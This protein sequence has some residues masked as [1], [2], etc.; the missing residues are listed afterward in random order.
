MYNLAAQKIMETKIKAIIF[1]M[2]GVLIDSEPLWREAM[3][4]GFNDLG[5]KFTEEDCK[6]TTGMRFKEV[7]EHWFVEFN[8]KEKTVAWFD[9]YVET[10][11]IELIQKGGR[12]IK[13]ITELLNFLKEK[14]YKIGLATSSNKKLMYAVLKH[15][16]LGH[17]FSATCSAQTLKYGKPHPK[18]FLNCASALNCLPQECLVIE[19]SVNGV[20]AAKAAFM[21]V[22][23]VPELSQL[24]NPKFA[25]ANYT[26]KNMKEVKSII[27]KF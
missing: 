22:I 15:L 11:L 6:K 10:L 26:C 3:I 23:A 4:K 16:K 25:I 9:K 18:V 8:Y 17:Y 1:D 27:S 19:D 13:G 20:I 5:F 21:K 24:Q 12:E 14:K 2:D 7:V